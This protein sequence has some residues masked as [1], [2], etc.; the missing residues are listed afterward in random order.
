MG[1]CKKCGAITRYN[2]PLCGRHYY[3]DFKSVRFWIALLITIIWEFSPIITEEGIMIMA[4]KMMFNETNFI[5]FKIGA[6]IIQILTLVG[7]L[8]FMNH[9][10]YKWFYSKKAIIKLG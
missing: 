7:S 9:L 3:F 5:W 10:I 4:F 1:V 6:I 2:M 8:M